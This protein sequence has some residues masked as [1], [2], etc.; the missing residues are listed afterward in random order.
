MLLKNVCE[1]LEFASIYNANRLKRTCQQFVCLNLA[2]LLETRSGLFVASLFL[3]NLGSDRYSMICA[4]F[5]CRSLDVLSA[6]VADELTTFYRNVVCAKTCS[7]INASAYAPN[8][9][10]VIS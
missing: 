7:W 2:A 5:A 9:C 1:V 4:K 10:K 6:E 8:S 3:S